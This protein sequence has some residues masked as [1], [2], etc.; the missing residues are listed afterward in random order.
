MILALRIVL[1][2][3]ACNLRVPPKPLALI[4][5]ALRNKL[6]EQAGLFELYTV[7]L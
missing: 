5:I 3:V 2:A 7:L 4:F 1:E 6:E